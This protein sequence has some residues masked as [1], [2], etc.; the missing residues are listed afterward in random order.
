MLPKSIH[1]ALSTSLSISCAVSN[2][3][4]TPWQ[5]QPC[6]TPG[7]YD[8]PSQ[9]AGC[10]RK[11]L[12]VLRLLLDQVPQREIIDDV[13]HILDAVLDGIAPLTQGIVLQIQDLEAGVEI[14]DELVDEQRP[15]VVA[16]GDRVAGKA[17][18]YIVS[19]VVGEG[20]WAAYQFVDERDERVEV[21]F[22]REMELVA[23]LE[24][25]GDYGSVRMSTINGA[26]DELFIT[27]PISSMVSRRPDLTA[28]PSSA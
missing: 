26:G 15:L 28:L 27:L 14:L 5:P 2:F 1:D 4:K 22:E 24:V 3:T 10:L 18:L 17:G 9:S 12:L 13:L 23:L 25:D 20:T 7:V 21:L 6:A 8:P 16:H 11:H 19:G